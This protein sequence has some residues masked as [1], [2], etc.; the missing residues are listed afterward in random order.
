MSRILETTQLGVVEY[1]DG[2]EIQELLRA[3][4]GA[5]SIP[6]QLLLLEHPPV[7]T[8]GRN[9]DLTHLR[10]TPEELAQRGVLF[11]ETGRGGDVTFHGPGQIVG[12]PVIDLNP[13]RRDVVRYVRDLEDVMIRTLADFGVAGERVSGRT[14]VWVGARK[15][16]A[17]GVR[18]SRW[19]TTHGFAFNV[20]THLD[21]FDVIV[22]CGIQDAEVTSLAHELGR[23]VDV[24]DVRERLSARFAEV[25]ERE[26]RKRDVSRESVQVVVWK[27]GGSEDGPHGQRAAR[28]DATPRILLV[29]RNPE[30]GAFWQPITGVIERGETPDEAARRE[31]REE[32]GIDAPVM[33]LD[34]VRD[35]PIGPEFSRDAGPNPFLLREHAFSM[36]APDRDAVR[37]SPEEHDDARWVTPDEARAL[38]RWPG[39]RR[40]LEITLARLGNGTPTREEVPA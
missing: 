11:R 12:Y 19:I 22:P 27:R 32:V 31:V 15:L 25:F 17:I 16:A 28:N 9:A 2:L 5:G 18:I 35:F 39:N 23:P 14:G 24:A 13:D 33:S 26:P 36:L 37:L 30:N 7:V 34:H 6:D 40:A 1:D 38:I 8:A 10:A 4:V 20:S 3:Q 21:D 29:H